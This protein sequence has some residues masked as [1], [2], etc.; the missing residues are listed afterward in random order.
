MKKLFSDKRVTHTAEDSDFISRIS[1]NT[2]GYVS[3]LKHLLGQ[4]LRLFRLS[5]KWTWAQV[6]DKEKHA[7]YN[8]GAPAGSRRKMTSY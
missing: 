8:N 2:V 4:Q 6:L 3:K 1:D 5:F 7:L